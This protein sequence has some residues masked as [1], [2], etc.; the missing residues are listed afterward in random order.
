MGNPYALRWPALPGKVFGVRRVKDQPVS[1]PV[2]SLN[3]SDRGPFWEDQAACLGPFN[4][5][6][7]WL[8]VRQRDRQLSN[9]AI[10]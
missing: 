3:K 9:P 5:Q 4:G 2:T 8:P 10:R 6:N 7:N 1:V